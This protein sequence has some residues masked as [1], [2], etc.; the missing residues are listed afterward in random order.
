MPSPMHGKCDL[1][2]CVRHNLHILHERETNPAEVMDQML[3]R[4]IV[5]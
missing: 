2:A 4:P 5:L 1:R 3:S